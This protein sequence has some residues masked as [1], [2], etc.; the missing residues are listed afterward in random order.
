VTIHLLFHD[1]KGYKKQNACML[2]HTGV[3]FKSE[4]LSLEF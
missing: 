1:R 4:V 3:L 2:L